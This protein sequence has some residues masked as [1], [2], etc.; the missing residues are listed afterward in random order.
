[1][2]D[3]DQPPCRDTVFA[4]EEWKVVYLVIQR[5]SPSLDTIV[6]IVAALSG[7]LNRKSDGFPGPKTLLISLQCIPDFVLVL[8]AQRSFGESCG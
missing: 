5:Q 2:G 4:D 1:V 3:G 7:F 8:E 6:R